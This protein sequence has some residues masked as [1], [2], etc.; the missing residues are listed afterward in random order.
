MKLFGI[1]KNHFMVLIIISIGTIAHGDDSQIKAF[2]ESGVTFGFFGDEGFYCYPEYKEPAVEPPE[3]YIRPK[4]YRMYDERGGKDIFDL[5]PEYIDNHIEDRVGDTVM[6]IY[7]GN[8]VYGI[9]DTI[10]YYWPEL[11]EGVVC[12]V[13]SLGAEIRSSGY[14]PKIMILRRDKFYTGTFIPFI[15]YAFVDYSYLDLKDSLKTIM[16]KSYVDR[17]LS[18]Y[19]SLSS[20]SNNQRWQSAVEIFKNYKKTGENPFYTIYAECYGEVSDAIP[21]TLYMV[22]GCF[23]SSESCWITLLKIHKEGSQWIPETILKPHSGPYSFDFNCAFD[24]DNDGVLEYYIN[25]S[26]YQFTDGKL[27][28]IYKGPFI[29]DI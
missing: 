19:D 18:F 28:L 14:P 23:Q 1:L 22:Y 7:A 9:I 8:K 17:K 29:G 12:V 26:I 3:E 25:N 10:V 13:R 6:V 15:E 16:I 2:F 11:E 20:Q 4:V 21:D 5:P 27:R 24:I